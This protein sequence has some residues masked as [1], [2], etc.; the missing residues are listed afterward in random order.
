MQTF[1]AAFS[2]SWEGSRQ[3]A[4][5]RKAMRTWRTSA[6]WPKVTMSTSKPPSLSTTLCN[7][8]SFTAW[9]FWSSVTTITY[10]FSTFVWSK[11]N[12]GPENSFLMFQ[13][14]LTIKLLESFNH[15]SF[16]QVVHHLVC[17]PPA[18]HS[19]ESAES[20]TS[21]RLCETGSGHKRWRWR[22]QSLQR[23]PGPRL[24]AGWPGGRVQRSAGWCIG[25]SNVCCCVAG[26]KWP[27]V[28]TD[29][30]WWWPGPSWVQ[31]PEAS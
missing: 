19:K 12:P 13:S 14:G 25:H 11:L 20:R 5:P 30:G 24:F 26:R 9:R 3:M 2:R 17:K 4:S 8:A 1:I 7:W 18:E 10:F 23:R 21:R 16:Q 27:H 15:Y 29:C 22:P 6:Q 28:S 31:L